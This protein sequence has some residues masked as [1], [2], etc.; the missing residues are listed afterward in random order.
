MP[1]NDYVCQKCQKCFEIFEK[2]GFEEEIVCPKCESLKCNK[3]F[4]KKM[5]FKLKGTGWFKDGYSKGY[6]GESKK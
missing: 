5:N 4:P 2:P 1:L 6:K 3:Q